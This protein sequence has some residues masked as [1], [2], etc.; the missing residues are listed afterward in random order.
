MVEWTDE[1]RFIRWGN[2]IDISPEQA[3][4]L[5]FETIYG[6]FD[7]VVIIVEGDYHF[8]LPNGKKVVY[9]NP[10]YLEDSQ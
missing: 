10:K 1:R 3:D 7:V 8:H 5:V 9:N 2:S 6:S 4:T